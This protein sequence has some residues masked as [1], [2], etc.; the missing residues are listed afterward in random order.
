LVRRDLIAW[1]TVAPFTI[2]QAMAYALVAGFPP[3]VGI[4]TAVVASNLGA[5]FSSSKFLVNRS[6]NAIAVMLAPHIALNADLGDPISRIVTLTL[7]IGVVPL[8]ASGLRP[9]AGQLH[10]LR[11]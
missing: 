3:S 6:T 2:G 11:Q 8:V 1:L 10:P 4:M 5:A 7:L 9:A